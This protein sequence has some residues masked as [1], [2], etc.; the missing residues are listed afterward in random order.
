M[1]RVVECSLVLRHTCLIPNLEVPPLVSHT[2]YGIHS[3]M[4]REV[5]THLHKRE[6]SCVPRLQRFSHHQPARKHG[7]E[8]RKEPRDLTLHSS[9][10]QVANPNLELLSCEWHRSVSSAVCHIPSFICHLSSVSP[11]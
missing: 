7:P 1:R 10:G 9:V 3:K 4:P 2:S 6:G 5:R 11:R 8:P